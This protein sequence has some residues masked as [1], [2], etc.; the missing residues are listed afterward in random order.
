LAK[1]SKLPTFQELFD[2]SKII[3]ERYISEE[4][5]LHALKPDD[6]LH[7]HLEMKIANGSPW[8]PPS[9]SNSSNGIPAHAEEPGFKGD[10]VLVN[11]LLFLRDFGYWVE[12]DYAV[13][14]GDVGRLLKVLKVRIQ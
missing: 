11:E 12:A 8:K 5:I 2:H 3:T 7:Q 14:V 1:K 13:P 6:Y 4:A 9:S 10:R